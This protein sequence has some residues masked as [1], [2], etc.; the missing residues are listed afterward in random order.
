MG[1]KYF[2]TCAIVTIDHATQTPAQL[3]DN[4]WMNISSMF[5]TPVITGK[6][7]YEYRDAMRRRGFSAGILETASSASNYPTIQINGIEA[8]A[9]WCSL[10][11]LVYLENAPSREFV[12]RVKAVS[13]RG[14][15]IGLVIPS[16]ESTPQ[17]PNRNAWFDTI[18]A[19]LNNP[20]TQL[21]TGSGAG[22]TT[23]GRP[24]GCTAVDP[25]E[26]TDQVGGD[27]A[28]P[29]CRAQTA[30]LGSVHKWM[31]NL[32]D[33]AIATNA[34]AGTGWIGAIRDQITSRYGS[35]NVDFILIP[36]CSAARRVG[37]AT[38]YSA[39]NDTSYLSGLQLSLFSLDVHL[40]N[41]SGVKVTTGASLHGVGARTSSASPV[42]TF[43][44]Q[45]SPVRFQE[46]FFHANDAAG[47]GGKTF[48]QILI[49][50]EL[51]RTFGYTNI[52][53]FVAGNAAGEQASN[54][55]S[56]TRNIPEEWFGAHRQLVKIN[57]ATQQAAASANAETRFRGPGIIS[58]VDY[59]D[60]DRLLKAVKEK[61]ILDKTYILACR[62]GAL[63]PVFHDETFG[64]VV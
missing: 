49:D 46:F 7:F 59:G 62:H 37:T 36:Q 24:G 38:N 39:G 34:A 4:N 45:Q 25:F 58:D 44:V 17:A 35:G 18:D 33:S 52:L 51:Q 3:R 5:T 22:G 20:T 57:P 56:G 13:R 40:T 10:F 50:L 11:D 30:T 26:T 61:G 2:K 16:L 14:T 42:G 64:P 23:D 15:Q 63:T 1:S 8:I 43:P 12:Q 29:T 47:T 55:H 41:R 19:G 48:S 60:F 6:G 9:N 31:V 27:F 53:G 32:A 54:Y 21:L 28:A